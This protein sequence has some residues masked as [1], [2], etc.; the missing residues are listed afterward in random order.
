MKPGKRDI[1]VKILITGEELTEL[2]RHIGSM[3]ESFGLDSRIDRYKGT[4]PI[5]F[6]SW[7]MDCL[8]AVMDVV[9]DD[10]EEY[11]DRTSSGYLTL[12]NLFERLTSEYNKNFPV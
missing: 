4:R 7:D 1:K 9:L 6:Y 8:L 5:G 12:K 3:A 10:P 11:P 2:K